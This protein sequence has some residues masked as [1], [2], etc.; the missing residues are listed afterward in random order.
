MK[1]ES[2]YD[3]LAQSIIDRRNHQLLLPIWATFLFDSSAV[4]TTQITTSQY[5]VNFK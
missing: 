2:T 5:A 1:Y 4:Q 3:T